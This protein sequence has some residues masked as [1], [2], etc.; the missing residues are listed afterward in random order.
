MPI[1]YCFYTTFSVILS[2]SLLSLRW[3]R[4]RLALAAHNSQQLWRTRERDPQR[5]VQMN[6]AAT[7]Q[8]GQSNAIKGQRL[9][10]T[11]HARVG[12]D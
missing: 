10:E 6:L 3:G 9:L 5:Q 1:F 4:I 12:E 11:S 7:P 8:E 2:S